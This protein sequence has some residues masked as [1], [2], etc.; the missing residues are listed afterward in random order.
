MLE[1]PAPPSPELDDFL[2]RAA[3]RGERSVAALRMA[4]CSFG[5][6]NNLVVAG[7]VPL[8]LEG[9]P[10]VA[11]RVLAMVAGIAFSL[12]VFHLLRRDDPPRRLLSASAVLDALLALFIVAAG[13]MWPLGDFHGLLSLPSHGILALAVVGSGFRLSNRVVSATAGTMALGATGLLLLERSAHGDAIIAGPTDYASFSIA[14]GTAA[15]I[16]LALVRRTRTLVLEGA[17]AA[18]GAERARQRLGVYVSQEIA[19]AALS[20]DRL[21]LGGQRRLITVL[22]SDLRGFTRYS[23]KIPPERLVAELNAYLDA[24]VSVIRSEGGMVDKYIGDAIMVVF[25]LPEPQPD[26]PLRALRAATR[27]QEAL[28]AHNIGR[29]ARGL[30]PLQQGIGVH[31]GYAIAGNIGTEDRLQ[32]TVIGDVVNLA[33]RLESL[34]KDH[35]TAVLFCADVVEAARLVGEPL[36]ALAHA[37]RVEVRG[38]EDGV[39]VYKLA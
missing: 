39:E 17:R 21:E 6:F 35:H 14:I 25:G 37:G 31:H 18:V 1:S 28:A 26:A 27:M 3:L 34:T 19:E 2:T 10:R 12:G 22:F 11:S 38:R 30:P 23:E 20:A 33:S 24:M 13:T 32:Y 29:T 15:L 5:L 16:A 36:P 9:N 4:I 7:G 8:L